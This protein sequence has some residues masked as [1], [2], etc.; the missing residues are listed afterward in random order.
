[1]NLRTSI[2]TASAALAITGAGVLAQDATETPIPGA[3][4]E[5]TQ[6]TDDPTTEDPTQTP[7]DDPAENPIAAPDPTEPPAETPTPDAGS[8]EGE[9]TITPDPVETPVPEETAEPTTDPAPAD[10]AEEPTDTGVA[11]P[12]DGEQIAGGETAEGGVVQPAPDGTA[13]RTRNRNRNAK[14]TPVSG[15]DPAIVSLPATGAGP[16]GLDPAAIAGAAV[17][18]AASLGLLRGSRHR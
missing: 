15:K 12:A 18:L 7:A 6:V 13:T 11:D 10:D 8:G 4:E 2:L 16:A 14:G 5:P 17:A 1:M 9:E 3:A